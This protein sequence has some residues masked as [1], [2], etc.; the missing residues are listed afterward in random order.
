MQIHNLG[1][2]RTF[3]GYTMLLLDK[4]HHADELYSLG[5]N[6]ATVTSFPQDVC[7]PDTVLM[8]FDMEVC[9]SSFTCGP[10]PQ[11]NIQTCSFSTITLKPS[12]AGSTSCCDHS[13]IRWRLFPARCA[14]RRSESAS[15]SAVGHADL[16]GKADGALS[17]ARHAAFF[18]C[19]AQI[20]AGRRRLPAQ[21]VLYN[22]ISD[23][24]PL[25][26]LAAEAFGAKLLTSADAPVAHMR[27]LG[28]GG[29]GGGNDSNSGGST[30]SAVVRL[31]L[32]AAAAEMWLFSLTTI[33]SS[34][35]TA[36]TAAST[37]CMRLTWPKM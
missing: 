37:S 6:P 4:P 14:R 23:S 30:S 12:P 19:A 10:M 20:E 35:C 8:N 36:A 2:M 27:L 28:G 13:R 34:A 26:R 7:V 32:Q 5:L 16:D 25:R 9:I 24:V 15:R 33:R 21:R 3:V 22:L 1:R 31:A 18:D 17:L 11:S 29:G